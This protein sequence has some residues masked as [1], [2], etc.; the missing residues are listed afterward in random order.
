MILSSDG[1]YKL[2]PDCANDAT[3]GA[4]V[5]VWDVNR[6]PHPSYPYTAEFLAIYGSEIP[7][8]EEVIDLVDPEEI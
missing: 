6:T 5:A 8:F 4:T 1:K 7:P 3:T 2:F